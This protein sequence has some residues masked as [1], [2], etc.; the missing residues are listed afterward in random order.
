MSQ[1]I[2]PRWPST[3]TDVR[4]LAEPITFPFSGRT[5]PNRFLKAATSEHLASYDEAD[6]ESRGIPSSQLTNFYSVF[7]RGGWGQ[8]LTGNIQISYTHLE[9]P[10]NAII[11]PGSEF[12][13]PRFE[14]FAA[15]AAAGKSHG[16]LIV[17]QVS[18]PGRQVT[19]AVQP[20]PISASAVQLVAEGQG[21]FAKPRAATQ[22]DID[23]VVEGF[24]HAA[25]YLERAGFDGIELHGA[26]GYLIAQFLS[27]TTNQRT[28]KYG[29]S[30][31]NRMRLVLEIAAAIK[32]RISKT[33]ILGI[34]INSVEFQDKGFTPEEAIVLCQALEKAGFDYVETSGGT[35]ENL[36]LEHKKESTVKRENY[37][38]EFAERIAAAVNQT[39][40]YTTGGLR[41]VGGMLSTLE[42]VDGLGFGR[43]AIQ[44]P[45]FPNDILSGKIT[46]AM[47]SSVTDSNFI[48]QLM[49]ISHVLQ[50]LARGEEPADLTDP[51]VVEKIL[52]NLPKYH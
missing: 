51:E 13:G 6:I 20:H 36:G 15:I 7:A 39:K 2:V 25:E 19:E 50:Q 31:E 42:G 45:S 38:I 12:S 37:F 24:A 16:S 17:G 52:A 32:K 21:P 48:G 14:A 18:H 3:S 10:G 28:D 11:P 43:V 22:E 41:T 9:A 4:R 30:L 8:I 1:R 23:S 49:T 47:K 26:H 35:Y 33:F 5:A 46:G 29:G 34:K 27:P 44:E 40:V